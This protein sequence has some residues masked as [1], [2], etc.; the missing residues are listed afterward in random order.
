ME[1]GGYFLGRPDG[2]C[3][4]EIVYPPLCRGFLDDGR[5][6]VSQGS[7]EDSIIWSTRFPESIRVT[8]QRLVIPG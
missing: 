1:R 5:R 7:T 6:L 4:D 2:V 3:C 8:Y